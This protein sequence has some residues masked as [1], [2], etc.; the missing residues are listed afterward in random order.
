MKATLAKEK[1]YWVYML[2]CSNGTY[3]TGYTNNLEKRFQ[4]HVAGTAKCKYTRSFKP[5]SIAQCWQIFADKTLAMQIEHHI[6]KL[7]RAKK[8][9]I[10]ADP[11][12]LTT[13]ARIRPYKLPK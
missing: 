9:A 3:Y 2:N 11:K 5:I 4:S 12:L 7:S 1:Y 8:Q 10:V 6:K 13:D